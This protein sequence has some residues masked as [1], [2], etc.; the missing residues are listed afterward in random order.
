MSFFGLGADNSTL[1]RLDGLANDAPGKI[2][3]VQNK[4]TDQ[5]GHTDTENVDGTGHWEI[6]A[7]NAKGSACTANEC[8]HLTFDGDEE[9]NPK[10]IAFTDANN[11]NFRRLVVAT[12]AT[13]DATFGWFAFAGVFDV[14]VEGTTDVAKDDYLMLDTNSTGGV[15]SLVTSGG[16]V[17]TNSTVAIACAAQAANSK[18]ATRCYLLGQAKTCDQ[19]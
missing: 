12:E 2:R 17:E 4:G 5:S 6:R 13:A 16:T 14:L 18:V 11:D 3:W 8:L 1:Q 15:N 10:V 19:Q 9:T 7:Y